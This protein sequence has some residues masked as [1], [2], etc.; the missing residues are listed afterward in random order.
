MKSKTV[1]EDPSTIA[2][3]KQQVADLSAL[4]EEQNR[5]IKDLFSAQRGSRFF[6][7]S[8]SSRQAPGNRAGGA[9]GAMGGSALPGVVANAYTGAA[10]FSRAAPARSVFS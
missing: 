8:P 10:A 7:G 5:R 6:K 4:D 2:L 3:R 1:K 9:P